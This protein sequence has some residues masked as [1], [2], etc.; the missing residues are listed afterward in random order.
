MGE[1]LPPVLSSLRS[2]GVFMADLRH[3]SKAEVW[4]L[5]A[6]LTELTLGLCGPRRLGPTCSRGRFLLEPGRAKVGEL[7]GRG[8]WGFGRRQCAAPAAR[9]GAESA[10]TLPQ[11]LRRHAPGTAGP[12]VDPAPARRAP[13]AAPHPG[14]GTEPSPGGTLFVRRPLTPSEASCGEDGVDRQGLD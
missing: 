14:V 4:G 7:R 1:R 13:C 3:P 9:E 2:A 12:M 11:T 10:R 8:G 5:L 6:E